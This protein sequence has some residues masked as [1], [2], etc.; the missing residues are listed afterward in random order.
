MDRRRRLLALLLGSGLVVGGSSVAGLFAFEGAV[1]PVFLGFCAF[2]IGYRVVQ[3]GEPVESPD[4]VDGGATAD[5]D[6]GPAHGAIVDDDVGPTHGAIVDD[7]VGAGQ[8]LGRL[9]LLAVGMLG[10]ATGVTM[11]A[12]TVL[13]PGVADAVAAGVVSVGGYA[14]AHAGLHGVVV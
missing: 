14:V 10:I 7:D 4:R 1:L 6:V 3:F 2:L 12:Q 5:D 13:D 9:A 8:R 11:F